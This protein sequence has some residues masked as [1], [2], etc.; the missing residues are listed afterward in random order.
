MKTI[1]TLSL[2]SFL[3]FFSGC[4]SFDLKNNIETFSEQMPE[5]AEFLQTNPNSEINITYYDSESVKNIISEI[6]YECRKEITPTS[7]FK[8]EGSSQT[9]NLTAWI[10]AATKYPLCIIKKGEQC[11]YGEIVCSDKCI[12]PVCENN[13]DCSDDSDYTEDIC[14]DGKTCSSKCVNDIFSDSF[15]LCKTDKNFDNN[16]ESYVYSGEYDN[17]M[18]WF[19]NYYT[20]AKQRILKSITLPKTQMYADVYVTEA[21]AAVTT[22]AAATD[23]VT[24]TPM[25]VGTSK[26][27]TEVTSITAQ[28]AIIVGGPCVNKAA[29]A[30]LGLSYP[31]CGASSGIPENQAIIKLVTH[32]NGKVALVV[33]GWEAD[34]TRRASRVIAQP[35]KYSLSGDE[36]VVSGT[37]M[38]DISVAVAE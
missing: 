33:A 13:E 8:L 15:E 23:A 5:I 9:A 11:F 28:N 31:A 12:V 36:I 24:V 4:T 2:L 27:D 22:S 21:A 1:I 35:D 19:I 26:L 29:A 6:N 7:L 20:P 16:Y 18:M 38:T 30:A 14:L 17:Q 10:D 3:V 37:S 25:S 34:D 32:T